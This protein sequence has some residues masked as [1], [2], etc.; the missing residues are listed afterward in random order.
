MACRLTPR[1]AGYW[2]K[3][4]P[5]PILVGLAAAGRPAP[6]RLS[7]Y[8]TEG[9]RMTVGFRGAA[10]LASSLLAALIFATGC[11]SGGKHA[12]NYKRDLYGEGEV[13]LKVGGDGMVELTLPSPRWA[14]NPNMKGKGSFK[15]DTLIFAADTA[16]AACQTGEARY[17]LNQADGGLQISGVGTDGCGGRRAAL[18]GSWQKA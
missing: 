13:Q 17:V 18:V 3:S 14:D 9:N 6:A 2:R 1:G 10:A 8:L 11:G 4:S 7:R 12:G 15:G 5:R 16:A